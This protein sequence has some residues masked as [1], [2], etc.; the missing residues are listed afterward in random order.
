MNNFVRA[1]SRVIFSAKTQT[2]IERSKFY[3]ENGAP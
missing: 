2:M 3:S 1:I